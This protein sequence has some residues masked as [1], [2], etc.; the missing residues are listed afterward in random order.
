[1]GLV[2]SLTD[3]HEHMVHG[4]TVGKHHACREMARVKMDLESRDKYQC[5]TAEE[6]II[7]YLFNILGV[8]TASR[9]VTGVEKRLPPGR[10]GLRSDWIK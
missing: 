7:I 1:M 3:G 2:D 5:P 4:V 8:L 6:I 10:R 9:T